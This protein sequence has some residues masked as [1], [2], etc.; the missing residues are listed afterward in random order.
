MIYPFI[1]SYTKIAC[2]NMVKSSKS[3]TETTLVDPGTTQ[4][5]TDV[6]DFKIIKVSPET[7]KELQKLGVKGDT[8][9]DIIKKLIKEH[10]ERHG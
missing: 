2:K 6:A 3:T 4:A 8:F 1:P 5:N 10:K 7:H 9:D